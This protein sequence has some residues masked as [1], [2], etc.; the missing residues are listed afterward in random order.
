MWFD[1]FGLGGLWADQVLGALGVY[2][3]L[4]VL[5]LTVSLLQRLTFPDAEK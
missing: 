2:P 4:R 1:R 3:L 5:P